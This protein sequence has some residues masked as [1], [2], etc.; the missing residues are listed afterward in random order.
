MDTRYVGKR[1]NNSETLDNLFH[2]G[3]AKSMVLHTISGRTI[4]SSPIDHKTVK[5]FDCLGILYPIIGIAKIWRW[6]FTT[7]YPRFHL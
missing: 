2:E 5:Q 3:I 1:R 4:M 7:R 6:I